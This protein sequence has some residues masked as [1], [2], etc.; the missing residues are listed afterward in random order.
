MIRFEN[1][2]IERGG[3]LLLEDISFHIEAG[4]KVGVKGPSGSGKS[5]LLLALLGAFP[6]SRG[7]IFFREK[8]VTP[9]TIR[10]VR[11]AMAYIGQEPVLGAEGVREAILLPFDFKA[12]HDLMPTEGR[13][14]E[15][16][17]RVGLSPEILD[18]RCAVVSGGE[19]QRIAIAR[20]LLLARKVFLADEVTSALD[21]R[22]REAILEIFSDPAF[23]VF[24]V[25]HD[26]EW[27]CRCHR[28]LAIEGGRIA[29]PASGKGR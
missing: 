13:L 16:L 24:S 22:S 6:L 27:L 21:P 20:A 2:A 25:A 19:K 10:E 4:E 8:P 28:I 26:A 18:S 3:K 7:R 1:V 29:E 17:S 9:K 5:T 15:A 12:N 11:S 14:R 23:T